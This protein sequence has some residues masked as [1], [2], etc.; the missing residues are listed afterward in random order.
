MDPFTRLFT[1]DLLAKLDKA[2]SE[3]PDEF[4]L[5]DMKRFA[6]ELRD[7][8][9]RLSAILL[10]HVRTRVA[11]L[12]DGWSA[13]SARRRYQVRDVMSTLFSLDRPSIK[14]RALCYAGIFPLM[15]ANC[16]R[17]PL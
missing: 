8:A 4:P 1:D 15:V 17:R 2:L 10:A 12:P 5:E 13:S 9:A 11:F 6:V 7:G 14:H 3:H 16:Y